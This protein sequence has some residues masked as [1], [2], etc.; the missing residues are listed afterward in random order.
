M[1]LYEL[2]ISWAQ[3]ANER[4]HLRWELQACDDRVAVFATARVDVLTALFD[5]G[6]LRFPAWARELATE[7][8]A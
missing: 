4:R 6:S 7:A 2:D 5:V 8:V 1:S 3:T